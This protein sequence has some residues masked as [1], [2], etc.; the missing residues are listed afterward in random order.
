MRVPHKISMVSLLIQLTLA[1]VAM[2][3]ELSPPSVGQNP[4]E[5]LQSVQALRKDLLNKIAPGIV[6]VEL[7][8]SGLP[9][10]E[11]AQIER[12][13]NEC[14]LQPG[15]CG[16][17]PDQEAEQ[18][19]DWCDSFLMEIETQMSQGK[20]SDGG[21]S[22]GDWQNFLRQMLS[23]WQTRERPFLIEGLE[24]S[25][26]KFIA[27]LGEQITK[28][29][30]Q[31]ADFKDAPMKPVPLHQNTGFVIDKG[32]VVTTF[33]A[34]RHLGP[35]NHIRVWSDAQVQYSTGEVIGQDPETNVALIRL[36]SP[37]AELLPTISLEK[38]KSAEV[39]DFALAF[40][41]AF[42]QPLSMRM[43]EIT[44]VLRKIPTFHYA[45]FLETS[46]PTSPGTLGA[47]LVNLDGELLGMS[48]VFMTQGTMTEV[49]FALPSEQLADVI[50][51]LRSEG[52][53]QRGKLG[54]SVSE[55]V[56]TDH[57]SRRVVVKTVEP[58]SSAARYGVKSGDVI[59]SVNDEPIH[60][61][62]HLIA[63]LS[64]YKP[65][66]QIVLEVLRQ[67][68]SQRISVDLDPTP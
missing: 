45:T 25:F 67:G 42:S 33:D 26:D 7:V 34:A 17:I 2:A 29:D 3:I 24:S 6:S 58:N 5:Y 36:S 54:V 12:W 56:S 4:P 32:L 61:K 51:Q 65:K 9:A 40:W 16:G 52:S 30:S 10:W 53:I 31:I 68:Q 18:W 19:R 20:V 35:Y 49:T 27:L 23:D 50:T 28:F 60:C 1:V 46:F 15:R 48:T 66:E 47:P 8:H 57:Q 38:M 43:G 55:L 62:T 22:M 11:M 59:L 21:G 64:R 41:H 63:N 37:G 39:G 13:S 44:G 14:R